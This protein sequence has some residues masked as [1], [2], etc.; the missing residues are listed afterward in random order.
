MDATERLARILGT[1]VPAFFMREKPTSSSRKP[2]C[3][4]STSTAATTTQT[5]ST[6]EVTSLSVVTASMKAVSARARAPSFARGTGF[7]RAALYG[8]RNASAAAEPVVDEQLKLLGRIG[9]L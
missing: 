5:V 9:F 6:A 7:A 1:T 2:A 4:K 3:M 8:G